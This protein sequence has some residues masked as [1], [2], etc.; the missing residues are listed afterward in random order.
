MQRQ[1]HQQHQRGI[2]AYVSY[3]TVGLDFALSVALCMGLGWWIGNKTGSNP[4]AMLGGLF[5]GAVAGFRIL[6]NVAKKLEK[7]D[8]SDDQPPPEP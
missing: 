4:W 5:L 8:K 1:Q 6:L 2:G 7:Q 3:T